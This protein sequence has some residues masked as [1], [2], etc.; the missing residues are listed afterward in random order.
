[1]K[2]MNGSKNNI[3]KKGVYMYWKMLLYRLNKISLSIINT[4]SMTIIERENK[5]VNK[6]KKY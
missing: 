1:M 4:V 5:R 6:P 2:I 3:K